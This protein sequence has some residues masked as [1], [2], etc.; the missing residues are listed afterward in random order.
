VLSLPWR[1]F[2]DSIK[3][4]GDNPGQKRKRTVGSAADIVIPGIP[5]QVVPVFVHALKVSNKFFQH[6]TVAKKPFSENGDNTDEERIDPVSA[7][8]IVEG[9][10]N[11]VE[12]STASNEDRKEQEERLHRMQD[13]IEAWLES[14]K[15]FVRN[16]KRKSEDDE[17]GSKRQSVPFSC[18][19][20]LW[21]MQQ[22]HTRVAARRAA[23]HLSELLLQKSRDC[24]FHLE[25]DTNLVKWV[26]N[27]VAEGTT[28]KNPEQAAKQLPLLQQESQ[29]LLNYLIEEGYGNLYPKIGVAQQRLRQLCP[30]LDTPSS[31]TSNMIDWR[32]LRDIA[33][34]FG[35]KEIQYIER[36][37]ARAHTCLDSLVPR[38]GQTKEADTVGDDEED[39]DDIDWEDGGDFDDG[40][41][42]T[43]DGESHFAAVE[44][45]LAAMESTG[46]VRGGELDIDFAKPSDEVTGVQTQEN[47]STERLIKCVQLLSHRHMPRLSAWV[48]GLTN[49]DNL[50]L[51]SSSLVLLPSA[52]AQLRV[53][54]LERLLALKRMVASV[55]SAAQRLEVVPTKE[56]TTVQS[57]A[58]VQRKAV[59]AN[60]AGERRHLSLVSSFSRRRNTNPKIQSRSKRIQIKCR[61]S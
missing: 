17:P 30:N 35:E 61:T 21:D 54:L 13:A 25:Q 1:H 2:I 23:L 31:G 29:M 4:P 43:L 5:T 36:L 58:S 49:A 42:N 56:D 32:R 53:E 15:R 27:I 51:E 41:S 52:T 7:T 14:V 55:L 28:W 59:G 57:D 12:A 18:F 34:Q 22:T 40:Y 3:M 44:R 46:A 8:S 38:L 16:D 45:T 24:R 20:Y 26:T 39:E 19:L 47:K 48:E 33:L 11:R 60:L 9:L 50:V 37:V 6:A 10:M